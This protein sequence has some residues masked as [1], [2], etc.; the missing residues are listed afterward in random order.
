MGVP[1]GFILGPLLFILYI[2]DMPNCGEN[3]MFIHF[4]DD[5]TIIARDTNINR[6]LSII[7]QNLNL[8]DEWLV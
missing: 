1:Q 8:V 3:L 4:A 7:Q 6:L 2:N 5:T